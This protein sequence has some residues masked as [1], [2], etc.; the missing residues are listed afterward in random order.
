MCSA[1][2]GSRVLSRG[3]SIALPVEYS[4]CT[5]SIS[6]S[7]VGMVRSFSTSASRR[8]IAM[9]KMKEGP[10]CILAETRMHPG[11]SSLEGLG[12]SRNR[13]LVA[14]VGGVGVRPGDDVAHFLVAPGR[15]VEHQQ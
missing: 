11:P 2:F 10:G 3:T 5:R 14:A 8:R 15:H 7:V 9:G 1:A 13:R 4:R 12:E 6:S